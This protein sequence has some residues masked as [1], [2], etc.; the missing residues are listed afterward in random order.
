MQ[1]RQS[2]ILQQEHVGLQRHL[3]FH[4]GFYMLRLKKT[5]VKGSIPVLLVNIMKTTDLI[6][7]DFS[8]PML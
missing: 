5:R 3:L 1:T 4:S 8:Q 2:N 6:S 7:L